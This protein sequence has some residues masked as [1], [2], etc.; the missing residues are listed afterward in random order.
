MQIKGF[1]QQQSFVVFPFLGGGGIRGSDQLAG[2]PVNLGFVNYS[3]QSTEYPLKARLAPGNVYS[4][5]QTAGKLC[6]VCTALL[7][8]VLAKCMV[9]ILNC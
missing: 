9:T 3:K 1:T 6:T 2:R 4:G 7:S 5:V 8:L